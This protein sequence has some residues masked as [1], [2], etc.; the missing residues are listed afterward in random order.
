MQSTHEEGKGHL[1]ARYNTAR[2]FHLAAGKSVCKGLYVLELACATTRSTSESSLSNS[3]LND[4][5]V[6][7]FAFIC[8]GLKQYVFQVSPS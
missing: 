7:L 8:A 6:L 3:M 5:L 2:N 1:A 4:S